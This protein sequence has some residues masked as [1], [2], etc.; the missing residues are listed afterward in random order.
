VDQSDLRRDKSV[1]CITAHRADPSRNADLSA[2]EASVVRPDLVRARA[3]VNTAAL[4]KDVRWP[5]I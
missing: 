5:T 2:E 4:I 1:R 3:A